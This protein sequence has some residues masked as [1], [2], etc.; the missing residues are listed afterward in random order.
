MQKIIDGRECWVMTS[1]QYVKAA[2]ANVEATLNE[3]GQ[4]LTSKATLDPSKLSTRARHVSG[5]QA[6]RHALLPRAYW[7]SQ[8]GTV[9]RS[10][11]T[12]LVLAI[13]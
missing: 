5:A 13:E 1:E 8:L 2:I 7:L 9:D 3:S 12:V 11:C 6:D 10:T 4:R